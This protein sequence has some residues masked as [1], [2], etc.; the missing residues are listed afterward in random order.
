[1]VHINEVNT[2]NYVFMGLIDAGVKVQKGI[3][4]VAEVSSRAMYEFYSLEGFEKGSKA[5]IANLRMLSLI[6]GL[7]KLFKGCIETLAGQRDIIYATL[8]FKSTADFIDV[9]KDEET[10]QTTY[11]LKLPRDK[12]GDIEWVKVLYGIGNPF[13][14]GKF[15]QKYGIYS[16]SMFT[17]WANQLGSVKLFQF[18]GQDWTIGNTPVLK[19][20]C[21]NPKDLFVFAASVYTVVKCLKNPNFWSLENLL[22]FAGSTGKMV[23]ISS[24]DY[25]LEKKY[26]IA[27]TIADVVTNNASL[28][29]FWIKQN[30]EREKRFHN[31]II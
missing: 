10:G 24:A 15:C 19:A 13:E 9:I 14:T 31:P 18:K 27:L 17:Q 4:H 23:L 2:V 11:S 3:L 5:G 29:A 25:M 7:N 28:F 30:N 6:P 8:V 12:K 1:M 22:K 21:N 26:I 16:F 20:S